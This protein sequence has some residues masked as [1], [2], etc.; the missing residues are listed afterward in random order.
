MRVVRLL[1][2]FALATQACAIDFFCALNGSHTSP[3]TNWAMAAT[4]IRAAALVATNWDDTVW[5]SNGVYSLGGYV[6]LTNRC[7]LRSVNGANAT[8]VSVASAKIIQCWFSNSVVEGFTFVGGGNSVG[9]SIALSA[10]VADY[11]VIRKCVF[12]GISGGGYGAVYFNASD[13]SVEDCEFIAC[14]SQIGGAIHCTDNASRTALFR[15]RFYGCY[16]SSGG[17]VYAR[18]PLGF[19]ITNCT[20]VACDSAAG[21]A[22]ELMSPLASQTRLAMSIAW[23]GGIVWLTRPTALLA[24]LTTTNDVSSLG[25]FAGNPYVWLWNDYASMLYQDRGYA[26]IQK[27]H[28]VL[29]PMATVPSYEV[30]RR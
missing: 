12:N 23:P 2:F 28:A 16:A 15:N 9:Q 7:T 11:C 3:F 4:N 25:C 1:T 20:A 22:I 26:T 13:S 5:V 14:E 30:R 24:N 27:P 21:S 8:T 17:A 18:S 19:S 10:A 29:L 6:V